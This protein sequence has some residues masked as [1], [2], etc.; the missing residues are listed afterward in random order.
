MGRD[1]VGELRWRQGVIKILA[2][3][4]VIELVEGE[5]RCPTDPHKMMHP[6]LHDADL[7]NVDMEA[8]YRVGL[9]L[10]FGRSFVTGHNCKNSDARSLAHQVGARQLSPLPSRGQEF[11]DKSQVRPLTV[12]GI[13]PPSV[14]LEAVR[15]VYGINS[16]AK[17]G[18]SSNG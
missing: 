6:A 18:L 7:R 10:P 3:T 1:E 14:A 9:E 13:L 4:L 17:K 15:S 12:R 16:V 5:I 11:P 2:C 8:A